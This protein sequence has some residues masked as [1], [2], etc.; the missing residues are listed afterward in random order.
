[1][2]YYM[3]CRAE[4]VGGRRLP[5]SSGYAAGA[6]RAG[7]PPA[8]EAGRKRE[9]ELNCPYCGH[10]DS[11]VVDSRETESQGS[12]PAPAGVHRLRPALHHLREDRARSRSPWSSATAARSCSSRR[13]CC[14]ASPVPAP[15]GTCRSS[16]CRRWWPTSSGNCGTSRPIRSRPSA[17]VRWRWSGCSRCDLVAYIRFASVYRQFDSVEEFKKELEQLAKEGI[18]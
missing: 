7:R 12:H 16:A 11:R 8:G 15:S 10:P 9:S 2:W 6:T 13:S 5:R 17:W 18:R 4:V 3:L 1:M 14:G